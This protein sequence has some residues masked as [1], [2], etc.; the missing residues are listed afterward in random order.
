[1]YNKK[2]SL[3]NVKELD[4]GKALTKKEQKQIFGGRTLQVIEPELCIEG[5]PCET[6][7][8]CCNGGTCINMGGII[9]DDLIG[10]FRYNNFM[11][12]SV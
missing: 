2:N 6:D 3:R 1:M 5:R 8:D 10:G 9:W 7:D 12:C 4:F 11:A